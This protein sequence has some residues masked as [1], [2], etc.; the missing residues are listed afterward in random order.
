MTEEEIKLL[1]EKVDYLE[2][3]NKEYAR[4]WRESNDLCNIY[5][6]DFIKL[7]NYF[8]QNYA[9]TVGDINKILR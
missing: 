9:S 4:L 3:K 8:I 2:K 5:R 7:K 1:L 6:E